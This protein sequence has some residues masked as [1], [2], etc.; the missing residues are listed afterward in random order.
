[1][2]RSEMNVRDLMRAAVLGVALAGGVGLAPVVAAQP[3]ATVA[4][5]PAL[6]GMDPVAKAAGRDVAGSTEITS[7]VGGVLFQFESASS[8]DTFLKNASS[9]LKKAGVRVA[10]R[11]VGEHN[12][13]RGKPAV[14]G[15]DVVAYFPEGGGKPT[16]GSSSHRVE[17]DGVVYHFANARHADRF[18][19]NPTRYEPSH[20]GWCSYAMAQGSFAEVDPKK[21]LIEDDRLLLFFNGVFNDTRKKWQKSKT[22]LLPGADANWKKESGE[23]KR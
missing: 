11:N 4:S 2:R 19:E 18:R 21:F 9:T 3:A 13:D 23:S 1:M 12:L 20:G 16:K 14:Q 6:G 7:V 10:P 5:A 22:D 17:Y 15:Y 8:R